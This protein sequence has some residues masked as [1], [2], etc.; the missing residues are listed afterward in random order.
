MHEFL[1]VHSWLFYGL[2][3]CNIR[4]FL[5]LSYA[6]PLG[7][8]GVICACLHKRPYTSEN[9]RFSVWKARFTKL[10]KPMQISKLARFCFIR[11]G[12]VYLHK[13]ATIS[14]IQYLGLTGELISFTQAKRAFSGCFV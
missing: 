5:V 13:Q 8:W 1:V 14:I 7:G 6:P 4:S 2:R 9:Y 3:I 12:S 10:H 11:L